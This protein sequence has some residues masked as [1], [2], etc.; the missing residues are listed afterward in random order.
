MAAAPFTES[1]R[2]VACGRGASSAHCMSHKLVARLRC[3]RSG[4]GGVFGGAGL[5]LR[6]VHVW[7][8]ECTN[9]LPVEVEEALKWFLRRRHRR[10]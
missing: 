7:P 2:E 8:K 6:S 1:F 10:R 4:G 5:A 9:G 3:S